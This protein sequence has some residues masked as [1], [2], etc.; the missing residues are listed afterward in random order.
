M[1]TKT[2]SKMGINIRNAITERTPRRIPL[3]FV[4]AKVINKEART[5]SPMAIKD[6]HILSMDD[7]QY[8]D[9]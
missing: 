7:I 4:L 2:Y 3:V 1:E 8:N 6:A 5:I 9:P